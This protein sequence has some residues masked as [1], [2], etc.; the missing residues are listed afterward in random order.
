MT[1]TKKFSKGTWH[2]KGHTFTSQGFLIG[3]ELRILVTRDGKPYQSVR[4]NRITN[5][6]MKPSEIV[7][8]NYKYKG[9]KYE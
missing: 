4:V 3:D 7:L 2:A 1:V 5:K 9:G 8:K 6:S